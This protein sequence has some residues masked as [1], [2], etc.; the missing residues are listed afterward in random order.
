MVC[1]KNHTIQANSHDSTLPTHTRMDKC[2]CLRSSLNGGVL[3]TL[4]VVL[5][6]L[7]VVLEVSL[8]SEVE[9]F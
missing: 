1:L 7:S 9:A 8:T 5:Q 6:T 3:Q 2:D 4:S